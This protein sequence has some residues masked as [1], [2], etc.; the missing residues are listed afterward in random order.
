YGFGIVHDFGQLWSQRG[1]MTFSGTPVRN[2]D[3]IKELL[4]AIQ[5]PEGIAVVKCSAHQ[6]TQDYISLGNGY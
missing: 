3:R 2:G 5:M 6:K 4:Y 1:F